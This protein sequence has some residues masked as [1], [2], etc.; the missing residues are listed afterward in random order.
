MNSRNI[1]K[2]R[3]FLPLLQ[4]YVTFA[5]VSSSYDD[6]SGVCVVRVLVSLARFAGRNGEEMS[7]QFKCSYIGSII[8]RSGSRVDEE[9]KK[10][11]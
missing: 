10:G 4:R 1:V 8:R 2:L 7:T 5:L 11:Q 6:S 3:Q 9:R